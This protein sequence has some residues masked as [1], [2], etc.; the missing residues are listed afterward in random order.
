MK[1]EK[2]LLKPRYKQISSFPFFGTPFLRQ[3]LALRFIVGKIFVMD[4]VDEDGSSTSDGSYGEDFFK[5][6]PHLFKRLEWWEE[7][8]KEDLPEYIKGKTTGHL[9]QVKE[10]HYLDTEEGMALT[11]NGRWRILRDMQPATLEEYTTYINTQ[12]LKA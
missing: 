12:K 3:K 4:I 5:D 1:E 11:I 2:D 9:Y 6:Y 8:A 10:Y 7:R